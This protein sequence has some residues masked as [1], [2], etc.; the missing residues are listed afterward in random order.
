MT[1]RKVLARRQ[2]SSYKPVMRPCPQHCHG[3]RGF[4]TR[5]SARIFRLTISLLLAFLANCEKAQPPSTPP[6]PLEP[7]PIRAFMRK[8][9]KK[10]LEEERDRLARFR[11][12]TEKA[13][14]SN[15]I[16]ESEYKRSIKK[17]EQRMTKNKAAFEKLKPGN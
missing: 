17:Y 8:P 6:P 15:S 3:K 12:E 11:I 1:E 9:S 16:K 7:P 2:Q 13:K 14:E 10:E 5:P 4:S